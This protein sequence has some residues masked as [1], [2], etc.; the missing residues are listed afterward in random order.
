MLFLDNL[1][2]PNAEF[3]FKYAAK[4][5]NYA[6]NKFPAH[7]KL[8]ILEPFFKISGATTCR[9]A[10]YFPFTFILN[11]LIHV[12]GPPAQFPLLYQSISSD[13]NDTGPPIYIFISC[14]YS[15]FSWHIERSFISFFMSWILSKSTDN[16]D[17]RT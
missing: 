17:Q 2:A 12:Q 7:C 13:D 4:V 3:D 11:F 6:G 1:N 14:L 16:Q 15:K 9:L 5:Y 10:Q 8:F